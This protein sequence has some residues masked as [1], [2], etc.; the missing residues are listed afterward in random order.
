MDIRIRISPLAIFAI[1]SIASILIWFFVP[2]AWFDNYGIKKIPEFW[3]IVEP[4]GCAF[5]FFAAGFLLRKLTCPPRISDSAL[6]EYEKDVDL[7]IVFWGIMAILISGLAMVNCIARFGVM[8]LLN[9]YAVKAAYI[10]GVTTLV[11]TTTLVLVCYS[12][13]KVMGETISRKSLWIVALCFFFA[14]YRSVYGAERLSLFVP[15]VATFFVFCSYKVVALDR[16]LIL[17]AVATI[18]ALL[19]AF[20]ILEYFRSYLPKERLGYDLD[21][22]LVYCLRRISMYFA[23]SVNTAGASYSLN[24][25]QST[26]LFSNTAV[27]M[28]E[29][30]YGMLGFSPIYLGAVDGGGMKVIESYGFYNPELNNSWGV[31]TPFLESIFVGCFFWFIWGV[32]GAQMY[33]RAYDASRQVYDLVLY[34][35]Y[36]ACLLDTVT[37]VNLLGT[38]QFLVPFLCLITSSYLARN[39]YLYKKII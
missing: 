14:V 33:V 17:S 6:I 25:I 15:I 23:A 16:R 31:V 38:S 11:Q 36:C 1:P 18:L 2:S 5:F 39:V 30:L 13:V 28:A 32:V 4:W 8:G 34:G 20:C 10:S 22:P 19:S 12:T 9:G 7:H 27:P 26:A 37:R 3:M 24:D 29:V 35:I 21:S